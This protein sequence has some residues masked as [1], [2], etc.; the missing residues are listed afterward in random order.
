MNK[1]LTAMFAATLAL[2]AQA[3]G[4][5]RDTLG[6]VKDLGG[7]SV[8][9]ADFSR[10]YYADD[11]ISSLDLPGDFCIVE[12]HMDSGGAGARGGHVIVAPGTVDDFDRRLA[13]L[14]AEVF[15]GRASLIVERDDLANPYRAL[16]RGFNYRLVENGFISDAGD[17][18]TFNSRIDDVARGYLQA[19]GIE[20]EEDNMYEVNVPAPGTPVHRLFKEGEH[21]Y[22]V[23]EDERRGLMAA[24]WA[25]EGVAWECPEP[26]VAVFRMWKPGWRHHFSTSVDECEAI[27]KQGWRCEG[28]PFFARR[29]GAP[30]FRAFHPVAGDHIFTTSAEEKASAIANGYVDEGVAWYV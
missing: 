23:S 24:G 29:E 20:T 19:F 18:A 25:Y 3:G 9:L 11:G 1:L 28:V 16:N 14:M 15:P 5:W 7:D 27:R 30:V 26:E 21:F 6:R 2:A 10:N 4:G 12:L 22:T 8:A 13:S 17:V